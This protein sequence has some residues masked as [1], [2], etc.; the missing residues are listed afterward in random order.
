[1]EELL[2]VMAQLRDPVSGC[3]WDRRQTLRSIVPHML[4][5]AYEV[6]DVI[7]RGAL[8]SLPDELGDL[9]FQVVFY[10]RIAEEE[11]RF[12]FDEVARRMVAKL[13]RRHPHVFGDEAAGSDEQRAHTWES[14]K[15]QERRERGDSDT[16]LL[17]DIPRAMP[18]LTRAV[19]L[20][21]RAARGGFDWDHPA[22][23]W[24]KVVEELDELREAL[25][26]TAGARRR[27]H[28][29]LGDV[30]LSVA[31]LARHLDVEPESALRD[32]CRRFEDRFRAVEA[33]L[34]E[35][36]LQP[37][38]EQRDLMEELWSRAKTGGSD[39]DRQ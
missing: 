8:E 2:A 23:V 17:A 5:E 10:A 29:E 20:G 34:A 14:I 31:S 3:P 28:E 30:L 37:G 24:D 18:A 1:M 12:D 33:G 6:A 36:G 35:R 7:E 27:M 11:Q 21:R 9:V 19:K 13:V 26:E 15:A 16:S 39:G 22:P 25:G 4:E 32:A 38:R